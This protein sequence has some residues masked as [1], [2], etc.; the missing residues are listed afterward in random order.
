MSLKLHILSDIK[1]VD[2]YQ[3]EESNEDEL[4]DLLYKTECIYMTKYRGC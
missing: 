4:K 3:S 1:V 2:I